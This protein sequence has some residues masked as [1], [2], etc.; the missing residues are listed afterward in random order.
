MQGLNNYINTALCSIKV[1]S[2]T[3]EDDPIEHFLL[4]CLDLL[5]V[6]HNS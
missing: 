4:L 3:I 1:N 2:N 6:N 5:R